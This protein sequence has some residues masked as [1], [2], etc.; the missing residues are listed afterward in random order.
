MHRS[1]DPAY[2]DEVEEYVKELEMRSGVNFEPG[3]SN[4]RSLRLPFDRV[5]ARHRS[6]IWY[7]VRTLFYQVVEEAVNANRYS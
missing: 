4:V 6:L 7:R 1:N 2:D 3:R 5:G